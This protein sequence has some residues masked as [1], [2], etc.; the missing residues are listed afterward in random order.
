[1]AKAH[2]MSTAGPLRKAGVADA[3]TG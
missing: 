3:D 2:D 1:V